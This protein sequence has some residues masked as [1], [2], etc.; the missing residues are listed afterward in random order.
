[1]NLKEARGPQAAEYMHLE[2]KAL[3]EGVETQG[4]T[5]E[6]FPD[7]VLGLFTEA[8]G[9]IIEREAAK[10]EKAATCADNLRTLM[11]DLG[12]S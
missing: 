10:S 3:T 4:I 5:V 1:M 7:D 12:Y 8:S 6:E 9:Q 11:K 2:A